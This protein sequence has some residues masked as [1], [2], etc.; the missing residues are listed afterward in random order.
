MSEELVVTVL[1]IVREGVDVTE[2]LVETEVEADTETVILGVPEVDG[3]VDT[4]VVADAI[5]DS[6]DL[7]DVV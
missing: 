5:D 6:E 2:G 7:Y 4:D 1:A 3:E